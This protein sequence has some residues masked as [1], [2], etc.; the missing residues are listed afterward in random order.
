[1][2]ENNAGNIARLLGNS[3]IYSYSQVF[4]SKNKVF[5]IMLMVVTFFDVYAGVAGLLS[6]LISGITAFTLGIN[7]EKIASGMYGF[8]NL[9][10]GLGLGLLYQP[11][12]ELYLILLFISILT[13][14]ITLS[15]EGI[16]GKYGL[17]YL[18]VPF[19]FGIWFVLIATKGYSA[20]VISERGIF[21]L[22]DMYAVGGMKMVNVYQWFN[23]LGIPEAI[24]V[25]FKSLSAILFQYHLFAGFLIA[26]GLLY[27]SRVSFV[28]SLVGFFSAWLFYNI[29]GADISELNYSYIGFNYIL[30]AIAIGGIFVVPSRRSLFWVILLT[31]LVAIT[32]SAT[33][34]LFLSF[35]LSVYSLPFN[36]IVLLFLYVLKFREHLSGKLAVVTIQQNSPELHAYSYSS[37]LDRFGNLPLHSMKLPFWGQWKIT[38]SHNGEITHKDNWRHAWDFEITDLSGSTYKNSGDE[39]SDYFCFNKPVVA[40]AD[41]VIDNIITDI[42]DN[43]AG[44]VNI[45]QN[46][47]N[48][49]VIKHNE[50]LYS[51][52]SHLKKDSI[53]VESGQT[54]KQGEIIGYCGNSGRSPYP[55]L[56]FQFQ[57]SNIIGACTKEYPFTSIIGN[58]KERPELLMGALPE[59]DECVQN[60][61]SQ[62]QLRDAFNFIP[63]SKLVFET[64]ENG[65]TH[66][67]TWEIR[68]DMYKNTSIADI[69]SKDEMWYNNNGEIFSALTY[70]G[71]K[72]SL[73]YYFFLSAYK[74]VLAYY[75]GL[76][77]SDNYPLD[78][79]P[80][81]TM[82]FIQDMLV[83]FG[84]VLKAEYNLDYESDGDVLSGKNFTL[85]SKARFGFSNK[86]INII[87]SDIAISEKGIDKITIKKNDNTICAARKY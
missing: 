21:A 7:K 15:M 24:R 45:E 69:D 31:P 37:Y 67:H 70:R 23:D 4:F 80:N 48:S 43:I 62:K 64:V 40:P 71:S 58:K 51:Q 42:E 18:S 73:L 9:M 74:V 55:H 38:Q 50:L 79:F 35:G 82:L 3:V 12:L 46:W 14:F 85:S 32:L 87:S 26:A 6:V 86:C 81:K 57:S 68:T 10:V 34:A 72:K 1:M 39:L 84:T 61:V 2:K 17:P 53:I 83:P 33:S 11:T 19:L 29:I 13:F 54:V 56:H 63:G 20:L 65:I 22:N 36:I 59:K 78:I 77:I 75:Q 41:G 27:F 16:I 28:M 66:N 44:Q 30:T 60:I 52:L 49:V 76:K 47:G 25:Y 5:A 8:N